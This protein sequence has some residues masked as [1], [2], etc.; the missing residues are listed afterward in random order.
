MKFF[1]AEKLNIP[2]HLQQAPAPVYNYD[3]VVHD[4]KRKLQECHEIARINLKQTKQHR[5]AQQLSK[6]NAP[7]LT[8][9]YKV[10]L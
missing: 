7:N 3:N 10:L 2:G 5:V 6:V 4:I 9:G 1:L 8:V